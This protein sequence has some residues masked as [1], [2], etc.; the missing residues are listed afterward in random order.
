MDFRDKNVLV[1]GLA[2]SGFAAIK[3]LIQCGARVK[4][5]DGK[6]KEQFQELIQYYRHVDFCFDTFHLDWL[7][8]IELI[9]MSPGVPTDLPFLKEA[10]AR[11]IPLWSELEL[12]YKLYKGKLIG[13]TGT[14][15]KTTTTTLVGDIMK[16]FYSK[17][18]VVGNI[19]LPFSEI[20]LDT[21]EDTVVVA[22]VSSFQLETI[23]T[24][25]PNISC[26]LNITP[27]HLNRHKTMDCYIKAKKKITKAQKKYDLCILNY[28]D[29]NLKK[30]RD[31][32]TVNTYFFSRK[33]AIHNG[34][35][36]NGDMITISK[37][38][39]LYS[40]TKISDLQV[41]G[42]HN[43]ENI[44]A[45]IAIGLH[46]GVPLPLIKKVI[47]SF[48]GVEHRIE[49]VTT[50]NGVKYYNDSK[51]TNP[52]AAIQG[53]K[54]MIRPTVLIAGGMDKESTFDDWI[55]AFENKVTYLIVF[56]ETKF[57]IEETAKKYGFNNIILV[58][59]LKDA[60]RNA[61]QLAKKDECVLLSPACASWDMFKSYEE[62]GNLFKDYVVS[63]GE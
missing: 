49:Y 36:L 39:K 17:V 23:H 14:N 53:I 52:D 59:D 13:I 48:K 46:M 5:Y 63:L 18:Y 33:E 62:R 2:R 47:T 54:A 15:G 31:S 3:L 25:K 44:M 37:N 60:V 29:I 19:G 58:D 24:F 26:I 50:L 55:L 61:F 51:A 10:E 45:S 9:V 4:A 16:A 20:V 28:D 40:V 35:F 56:G 43:V 7:Q 11:G 38:D 27:D 57:K 32:L 1:V 12:A 42:T 21:D 6:S 30:M 22:E 41:L 8:E 34:V